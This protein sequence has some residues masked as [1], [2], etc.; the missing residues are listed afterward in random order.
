MV[1]KLDCRK[2]TLVR[3]EEYGEIQC[4]T[5]NEGAWIEEYGEGSEDEDGEP[6]YSTER[7]W[8]VLF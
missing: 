4:V 3:D 6:K 7:V 5:N 8:A 1:G 2:L